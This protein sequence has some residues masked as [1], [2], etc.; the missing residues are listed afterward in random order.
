MQ[1]SM[2]NFVQVGLLIK[3]IQLVMP[4]KENLILKA[5]AN[6]ETLLFP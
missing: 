2:P 1:L 6:E 3:F 5:P 4:L